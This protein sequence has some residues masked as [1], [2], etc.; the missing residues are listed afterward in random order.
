[1]DT[2]VFPPDIIDSGFYKPYSHGQRSTL[3]HKGTSRFLFFVF[4]LFNPIYSML[5]MRVNSLC[6]ILSSIHWFCVITTCEAE[7]LTLHFVLTYKENQDT[8]CFRVETKAGS[9]PREVRK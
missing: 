4:F 9:G 5:G 2:A 6:L 1:M 3:C 8:L 7:V